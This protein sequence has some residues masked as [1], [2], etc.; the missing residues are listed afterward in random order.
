MIEFL[1]SNLFTIIDVGAAILVLV[2]FSFVT[3]KLIKPIYYY[4]TTFI[5]LAII[6]ALFIFKL[7]IAAA[8]ICILFIVI[9]FVICFLLQDDVR[10]FQNV[11]HSKLL[12]EEHDDQN[13][14]FG[15]LYESLY[16]AVTDMSEYKTGAIIV[17]E[18]SNL[19]KYFRNFKEVNCPVSSEMLQTIF[20]KGTPL[21]DGA[22]IIRGNVIT[23][24]NAFF[25]EISAQGLTGHY[26]SR[27][28]AALGITEKT[29]AIV[30]VVSEETG[31]ISFAQNGAIIP[32]SREELAVYLKEKL[33]EIEN[34]LVKEK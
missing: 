23:R 12:V 9:V 6:T 13:L 18:N 25:S 27:H 30:I 31:R 10:R 28:R 19:D 7:Y 33:I 3:N 21:H 22:V 17:L 4:L 26:G 24:A 2:I 15:N 1:K 14:S 32:I 11:L 8:V 5:F 20:Y 16:D 29:N 34:R